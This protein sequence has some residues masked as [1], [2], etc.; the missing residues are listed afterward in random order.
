MNVWLAVCLSDW[1]VSSTVVWLDGQLFVFGMTINVVGF[2]WSGCWLDYVADFKV[3]IGGKLFRFLLQLQFFTVAAAVTVN[4]DVAVKVV[5]TFV[6]YYGGWI[7]FCL[8]RA[9][10]IW[11]L[12]VFFPLFSFCFVYFICY[13]GH[14]GTSPMTWYLYWCKITPI[15]V[16]VTYI[17]TYNIPVGLP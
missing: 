15:A 14:Y 9:V 11:C 8:C 17:H 16:I 6:G 7:C 4:V 12:G 3:T 10:L 5:A 13:C 2:V 1:M